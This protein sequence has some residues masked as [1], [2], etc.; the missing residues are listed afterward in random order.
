MKRLYII[1]GFVLGAGT[2][3][4]VPG[5]VN[6]ASYYVDANN[7]TDTS[8]CGTGSGSNACRSIMY[9][10]N[11]RDLNGG[12]TVNIA[13]GVYHEDIVVTSTDAGSSNASRVVFQGAGEGSTII[14]GTPSTP[15][16]DASCQQ[17]TSGLNCAGDGQAYSN[18]YR[19]ALSATN[20]AVF[21]TNWSQGRIIVDD[22][23]V[24]SSPIGSTGST[25]QCN[26]SSCT[27]VVF[28]P[29]KPYT[30]KLVS[31]GVPG[32]NRLPGSWYQAGGYL[33]VRTFQSVAPSAS[34]NIEP[35]TVVHTSEALLY[36]NGT[37]A[38]PISYVT[39]RGMTFRYS[40]GNAINLTDTNGWLLENIEAYST[41]GAVA[42]FNNFDNGVV[43]NFF[44]ASSHDRGSDYDA[45]VADYSNSYEMWIRHGAGAVFSV[46]A[47]EGENDMT[48][49]ALFENGIVQDGWNAGG[50]DGTRDSTFRNILFKNAPNHVF[51]PNSQ[52]CGSVSY[53]ASTNNRIER[54]IAIN[55]QEGMYAAGPQNSRFY[56]SATSF[57][58]IDDTCSREASGNR[59]DSSLTNAYNFDTNPQ[60]GGVY[61]C[62]TCRL[63][64]SADYNW[65]S[66]IDN[67]CFY[68]PNRLQCNSAAWRSALNGDAHSI[69]PAS[70]VQLAGTSW[71]LANGYTTSQLTKDDFYPVAGSAVID[72]GN[73]DIDG[74]GVLETGVGGDDACTVA[75]HC[76][77]AAPDIGPY[78]YGIDVAAVGGDTQA[79][80]APSN[81]SASTS[82]SGVFVRIATVLS[83][84][85]AHLFENNLLKIF[86]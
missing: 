68:Y 45:P 22:R 79:P 54:V 50:Y 46:K 71:P 58:F 75:H 76:Y 44:F 25:G 26:N 43:R 52:N 39:I 57:G 86:S 72:A 13:A 49:G 56:R 9:L 41:R 60:E 17:C 21:E 77:G 38:N 78:E 8:G 1:F 55:G 53:P 48:V 40:G 62:D 32:V 85:F 33:Y 66:S 74:D 67:R 83:S 18:V 63:N 65:Y 16:N 29:V 3:I 69:S 4:L 47:N 81:L 5:L 42:D 27:N 34:I 24:G 84:F 35:A 80:T 19:C 64:T 15:L 6:A 37:P 31:N 11:N 36:A 51:A 12:D 28:E 14:E 30:Y 61:V 73:P 20:Y 2:L 23:P 82:L 7:G 70:S 59:V 10:V